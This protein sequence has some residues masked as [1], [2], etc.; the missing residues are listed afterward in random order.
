[1]DQSFQYTGDAFRNPSSLDIQNHNYHYQLRHLYEKTKYLIADSKDSILLNL[2]YAKSLILQLQKSEGNI[3]YLDIFENT[4]DLCLIC[5]N[6][7]IKDLVCSFSNCDH[8]ICKYCEEMF[9]LKNL[10]CPI[11]NQMTESKLISNTV[12]VE[13]ILLNAYQ[14]I[15]VKAL[16]SIFK[17]IEF[18]KGNYLEILSGNHSRLSKLHAPTFTSLRNNY[19]IIKKRNRQ[20][21]QIYSSNQFSNSCTFRDEVKGKLYEH[22]IFA[23]I[24][25]RFLDYVWGNVNKIRYFEDFMMTNEYEHFQIEEEGRK[26]E[27]ETKIFFEEWNSQNEIIISRFSENHIEDENG[28]IGKILQSLQLFLS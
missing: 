20:A 8:K 11:E 24:C 13:K 19:L 5:S 10:I 7:K 16:E 25:N 18:T 4:F 3:E 17:I 26:I 28:S 9:H 22:Y 21:L 6:N 23:N 27:S 14:R 12:D 2:N 1:M 15:T